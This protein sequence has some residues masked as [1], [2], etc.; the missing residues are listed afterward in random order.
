G[1]SILLR[2]MMVALVIFFIMRALGEMAIEKPF[3]GSFSKYTY[4]YISPIA[5]YI[6]GWH[7]WFLGVV[8]CLAEITAAG[9]YMQYWFPNIPRWTW[10]LLALL[11][12]S[13]LNFLSVKVFGELEFLFAL[14]KLVPITCLIVV[15]D[16]IILF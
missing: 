12:M 15:E 4:D 16:G 6:T 11:L 3:A 8:T 14:I 2:Y 13:A 1:S 10:A 9:I 5:D 7:Y